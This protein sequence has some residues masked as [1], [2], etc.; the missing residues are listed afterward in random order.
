MRR[1]PLLFRARACLIWVPAL[2]VPFA[3]ASAQDAV[4]RRYSTGEIELIRKRY[5]GPE[6]KVAGKARFWHGI[7]QLQKLIPGTRLMGDGVIVAIWDGGLI[8]AN[9]QDLTPRVTHKDPLKA[10]LHLDNH[11]T[12]VA[13]TIAGT[14]RGRPVAEGVAPGATIW[15]YEFG[16]DTGEMRDLAMA[17][18]GVNV[19]NHSYSF[20]AGWSGICAVP[21]AA[22]GPDRLV[23][24]WSGLENDKADRAFG[25]YGGVSSEFDRVAR[26]QPDWTMVVAAGNARSPLLDPHNAAKAVSELGE[27][28]G[29]AGKYVFDFSGEHR[30]GSCLGP[31][32]SKPHPSNRHDGEG[33]D[34]IPPGP[35]AAK[36]VI[37]VGAMADPPFDQVFNSTTGEY[38]PLGRG[39]VQ[40]T[41]FSSWGPVDDGRVKPDVIANGQAVLATAIPERCA[42]MPCKPADAVGPGEDGNYV[43]MSGTSM[44]TPVVS[45]TLALLNQVSRQKR[46]GR[47]LRSDEAKALLIHT[48]LSPEGVNGPTYRVGWGAIQAE[49]AGRLLISD[50]SGQSLQMISVQKDN[51]SEL[52]FRRAGLHPARMTLVWLDEEAAE[53]TGLN[54]RTPTLV[55]D[56]DMSLTSPSGKVIRPWTLDPDRPSDAAVRGQNVRDNVERIDVPTDIAD[57]EGEWTLRVAGKSWPKATAVEAALAVWGFAP[58]GGAAK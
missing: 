58:A 10:S 57:E 29:I 47:N 9:H 22:G 12:H 39:H 33:F 45:G 34:S 4:D 30:L 42:G 25:Q 55:N 18:A 52:K 15:S 17:K 16:N 41:N 48:A 2:A 8:Q 56:L 13:G 21:A 11:A 3:Y 51:A 6:E 36:N 20:R 32:S 27:Y 26:S 38:K 31:K 14:G 43:Q 53:R 37:T 50:G 35:A 24:T 46:S 49:L 7:E 44:A 19:S 28:E 54:D 5:L 1:I 23:W 40:T